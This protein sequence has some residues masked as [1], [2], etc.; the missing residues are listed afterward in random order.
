MLDGRGLDDSN[1]SLGL[2]QCFSPLVGL[3]I[4]LVRVTVESPHIISSHP[5]SVGPKEIRERRAERSLQH[6]AA[7]IRCRR[8]AFKWSLHSNWRE[9]GIRTGFGGATGCEA[10]TAGCRW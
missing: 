5:I 6:D 4:L 7:R 3:F 9:T 2:F 10:W 8:A 1:H